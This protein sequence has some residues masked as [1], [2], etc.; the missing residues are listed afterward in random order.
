MKIINNQTQPDPP[1][2]STNWKNRSKRQN[3]GRK[4]KGGQ[5]EL[6]LG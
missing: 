2:R 3:E 1:R 5:R 6:R 4:I